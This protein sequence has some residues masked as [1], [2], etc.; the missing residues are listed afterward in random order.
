MRM[1]GYKDKVLRIDLTAK[2]TSTEPLRMDWAEKYIGSKGLSIRYLYEELAPHTDPLSPDNKLLLTTGPFTGTPVPCSGKLAITAKSPATGTVNDASIGGHI[3]IEIKYAGYDMI[4]IEGKLDAPG[5]LLI[6]DD[7][8]SFESAD[9]LWGRG[10]HEAER[11]LAERHGA[12]YSILSIGPA[13]ENLSNMACINCDYYRQ[14]GRGGLGAVMGSKN[15]KAI[16]VHGTGGVAVPDIVKTTDRIIELLQTDVLVEDNTF[17]FDAGTTAFLEACN[18]GGI[19]PSKNFTD[20]TDVHWEKYNGDA[21]MEY[22]QG[23]RGCGDCGLGCGNF[24]Q[25][26]GKAVEGPEYE[27]ISVAGPNAGVEDPV[28]IME[29]NRV[30][31]DMGL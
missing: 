29:Y 4:I 17:V 23:K 6:E 18:D 30:A 20:T 5:Y 27:T 22:R 14:A 24:M 8:I 10:S 2:Q 25:F 19:L 7:K 9:G 15:L 16:V 28:A 12:N 26:S 21:L 3:G 31:D 1:L 13:G 11:T